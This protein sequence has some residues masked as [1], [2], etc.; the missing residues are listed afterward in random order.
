[1]GNE[2]TLGKPYAIN[3]LYFCF[4]LGMNYL[5]WIKSDP[6]IGWVLGQVYLLGS[7]HLRT[8]AVWPLDHLQQ[9]NGS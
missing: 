7:P 9:K 8:S 4:E 5:G 6:Q 1:M 2:W 3:E